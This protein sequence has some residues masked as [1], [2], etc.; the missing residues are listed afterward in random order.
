MITKKKLEK[1][2]NTPVELLDID[3]EK[4][5]GWFIKSNNTYL[6]L[7]FDWN[8]CVHDYRASHIKAIKFLTNGFEIKEGK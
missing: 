2:I 8:E 7:P 3:D 6:L 4:Y 1:F 5:S